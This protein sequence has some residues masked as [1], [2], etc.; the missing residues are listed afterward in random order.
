MDK[1]KLSNSLPEPATNICFGFCDIT[2]HGNGTRSGYYCPVKRKTTV[3]ALAIV[4]SATIALFSEAAMAGAPPPGGWGT[5]NGV[6]LGV[7]GA[8]V[9]KGE[10]KHA[11]S[12]GLDLTYFHRIHTPLYYWIS[13]G[14]RVWTTC[15]RTGVIPYLET[16]LSFLVFNLGVG[17]GPGLAS[18][19]IPRH[20]VNILISIAAPVWTHKRG[21]LFYLEPYYRPTWDVSG[22]DSPAAH[23]VGLMLKWLFMIGSTDDSNT[24]IFLQ[25]VPEKK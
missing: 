7:T 11:V 22:D 20:S 5:I 6:N 12:P 25:K 19:Y 2:F 24:E 1:H 3:S 13:T 21:R 16:G 14:A 23:E 17:Y 8:W 10:L 9:G 15:C 4:I 18:E